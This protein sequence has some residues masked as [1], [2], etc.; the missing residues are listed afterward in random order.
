MIDKTKLKEFLMACDGPAQAYS[1]KEL[2]ELFHVPL[3]HETGV[4]IRKAIRELIRGGCPIGSCTSGYFWINS[5]RDLDDYL[6]NIQGRI[7]AMQER[8]SDIVRGYEF[9][10][11]TRHTDP[12]LSYKDRCRYFVIYLAE[13]ACIPYQA[14]W[15]IAYRKFSKVTK[16]D[17]VNLPSWYQGSVL[18]YINSQGMTPTLYGILQELETMLV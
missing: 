15:S 9:A 13:T 8:I 14:V 12:N 2:A 18:N 7:D 17:T 1:V 6:E 10:R 5:R 3:G 16:V 11:N 4:N